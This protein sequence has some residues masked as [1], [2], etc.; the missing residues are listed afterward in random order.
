M[1]EEADPYP[2]LPLA[3]VLTLLQKD[4]D[5]AGR[6]ELARLAACEWIEDQRSDLQPPADAEEGVTFPTKHEHAIKAAGLFAVER[7]LTETA[8]FAEL[9]AAGVL[10]PDK[11]VRS[12]IGLKIVVG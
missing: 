10:G 8:A 3:A 6:V 11:S 9:G 5:T 4:G 1:P 2:W 12:L 7:L